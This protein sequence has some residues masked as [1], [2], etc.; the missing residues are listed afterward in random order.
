MDY[1]IFRELSEHDAQLYYGGNYIRVKTPKA[2][3]WNWRVVAHFHGDGPGKEVTIWEQEKHPESRGNKEKWPLKDMEFDLTLPESG[4]QNYKNT[5]IFYS[6]RPVR[7]PAKMIT[8]QNSSFS[9]IMFPFYRNGQIPGDLYETHNFY[10][11][12]ESLNLLFP[13]KEQ[14]SSLSKILEKI[15]KKQAFAQALNQKTCL[16]QGVYSKNPSVWMGLRIVGELVLSKGAIFPIH[17]A[18]CR[19]LLETFQGTGL[20]IQC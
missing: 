1:K 18:F 7:L 15:E 3:E 17:E 10:L 12:S 5:A 13:A 20:K 16:T 8:Q 4:Y 19:D 14:S 11:G 6:K 9:N 2:P